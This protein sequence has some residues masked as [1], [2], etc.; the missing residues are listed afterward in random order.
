MKIKLTS[1]LDT[2]MECEPNFPIQEIMEA[3]RRPV[4]SHNTG[5][6]SMAS[7]WAAQTE[8]AIRVCY[9]D[10]PND[11]R[12]RSQAKFTRTQGNGTPIENTELQYQ[13]KRT[14]R[15]ASPKAAIESAKAQIAANAKLAWVLGDDVDK[16]HDVKRQQ[17]GS[18]TMSHARDTSSTCS[19]SIGS[20]AST[21]T[22]R[23]TGK[24]IRDIKIDSRPD[25]DR[26]QETE[27]PSLP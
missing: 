8:Q 19:K 4:T 17:P 5:H 11:R 14:P 9:F 12:P 7:D 1:T 24:P 16:G 21:S 20:Q 13:A 2:S 22:S 23:T 25:N 6:M 18:P 26:I 15:N 3:P 27:P 10:Y